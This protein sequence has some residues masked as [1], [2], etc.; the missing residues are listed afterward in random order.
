MPNLLVIDDDEDYREYLTI[1][2]S[3]RGYRVRGLPTGRALDNALSSERF[4]AVITDL[5]MPGIDGLEVVQAIKQVTPSLPVIGITGGGAGDS[6]CSRA[7]V[8][9]GAAVVLTKPLDPAA[10][11]DAIKRALS[12]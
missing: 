3:R 2:L 4:D 12:L 11:F 9:F 10:L 5:Y 7:M 8:M 6:I 1:L